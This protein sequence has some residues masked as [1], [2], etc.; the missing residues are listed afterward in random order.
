MIATL[1][2][3]S[4]WQTKVYEQRE[5]AKECPTK[6]TGWTSQSDDWHCPKQKIR[7]AGPRFFFWRPDERKVDQAKS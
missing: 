6:H 7:H 1:L 4:R 2:R 3:E 5:N